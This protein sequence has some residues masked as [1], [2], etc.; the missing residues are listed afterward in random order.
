MHST[1]YR[2]CLF[3]LQVFKAAVGAD[4]RLAAQPREAAVGSDMATRYGYSLVGVAF[5]RSV[6]SISFVPTDRVQQS[7]CD[8]PGLLLTG[9]GYPPPARSRARSVRHRHAAASTG[10]PYALGCVGASEWGILNR[11]MPAQDII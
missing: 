11:H 7:S 8:S 10:S 9:A 3:C 6:P 4:M 1:C 2:G 5:C